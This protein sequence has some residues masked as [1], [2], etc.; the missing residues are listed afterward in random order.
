MSEAQ[1]NISLMLQMG[2]SGKAE[3][4]FSWHK[5]FT[6]IHEYSFPQQDPRFKNFC[7]KIGELFLPLEISLEKVK[8]VLEQQVFLDVAAY[9][10]KR[11][12]Y[13]PLLREENICWENF[14]LVH[15][16][17]D[18]SGIQMVRS[19]FLN[20]L[21]GLGTKRNRC[22][23]FS[24]A[25]T[26]A[27]ENAVKFSNCDLVAVYYRIYNRVHIRYIEVFIVNGYDQEISSFDQEKYQEGASLMR[28]VLVMSS[29]FDKVDIEYNSEYRVMEFSSTYKMMKIKI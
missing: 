8:D 2:M 12:E 27:I 20:V 25:I 24:I 7:N 19:V 15:C 11:Q 13:T 16:D 26:E 14:F 1:K 9:S 10:P 6:H 3:D 4:F 22:Q 17:K 29:L 5:L 21:S 23:N 28:G 18:F